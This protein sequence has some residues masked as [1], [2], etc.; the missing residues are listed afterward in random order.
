M[1]SFGVIGCGSIGGLTSRLLSGRDERSATAF[2]GRAVLAGVAA[3]TRQSAKKLADELGLAAEGVSDLLRRP[4]ID[5]VCVCTPSGT[6]ADIA[7]RALEAGKHVLV[8]KPIDVDCMAADRLIAASERTGLTLG[9]ISQCRFTPAAM[10]A[11]R[12]IDS[13]ALGR[14]TSLL[15]EVPYWRSMSYYSAS[16]WRGTRSLDGGGALANQGVHYLDLAQWLGGPVT[17]VSA[18]SAVLAHEGIEVEDT[19]SASL[20]LANG[21]L[22]TLLA[23]TAAYP[24]RESRV[25]V[26]GDRGSLVI[27]GDRLTY[28]HT[29]EDAQGSDVGA[30][31]AYG[32][33]NQVARLTQLAAEQR[34]GDD[35]RDRTGQPRQPHRAQILDFCRAVETGE[36][37]IVDGESARRTL[38]VVQAVYRSARE[39]QPVRVA[40]PCLEGGAAS[41]GKV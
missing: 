39:R 28:F 30:Y 37:P 19:I 4:D 31:G 1:L 17:E 21:A 15:I 14:I 26:Q 23:S 27:E 2:A 36:R 41:A 22:G 3:R 10:A 29:F 33:Q 9:V 38:A 32:Q 40:S 8:E 34:A 35:D 16:D 13:G 12:A 6:H 20:R 7:V 25:S 11:Q 5:A 18:H 24:G